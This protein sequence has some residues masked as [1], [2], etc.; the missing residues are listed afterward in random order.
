MIIS[1]LNVVLSKNPIYSILSLVL[2]FVLNVILLFNYNFFFLGLILLVIY[3]GAIAVLFL[4][5]VMMLNVGEILYL[6]YFNNVFPLTLISVSFFTSELFVNFNS[7]VNLLRGNNI[8]C[9]YT[10]LYIN[11]VDLDLYNTSYILYNSYGIYTLLCCIIMFLSMIGAIALTLNTVTVIKRQN[12]YLQLSQ[13]IY[14]SIYF[15]V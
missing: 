2:V 6:E 7:E 10:L 4:F 8:S 13:N 9:W 14:N 3:V 1:S 12:L 15:K 11:G 5:V